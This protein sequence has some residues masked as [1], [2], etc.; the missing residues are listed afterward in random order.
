M[1]QIVWIKRAIQDLNEIAD[2][3]ARNSPKY[4]DLTV[5]QIFNR[6]QILKEHP[7]IGRIVPEINDSKI[8]ELIEGNYR[9]IYEIKGS[10]LIEILT[11][12]H[13]SKLLKK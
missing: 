13:S 12:H 8:R 6:T 4:A 7:E 1:V 9:I 2:Y 10:K 3:I 11:I 5:D